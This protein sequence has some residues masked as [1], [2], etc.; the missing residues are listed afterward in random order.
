LTRQA[1]EAVAAATPDP[2]LRETTLRRALKLL[3][4]MDWQRPPPALAQQLH[5]LIR[6]LTRNPDPYAALKQYVDQLAARLDSVWHHRFMESFPPFEAAV[7]MAIVGNQLDAASKAQV[8][9]PALQA[10]FERALTTP[11]VGSITELEE[12]IRNAQSILYL[13][14]NAGEIVFDR[15]LLAELPLGRFSVAVRGAPVLN[16]A[17]LADA[18]AAELGDFCDLMSN[19]SDAPGTLLPDCS[20]EFR[21]RF[22]DADLVLSKGQGNYESLDGIDK[23]IVFLF[24]VKC[25]VVSAALGCPRGSAVI[26]H[27]HPASVNRRS[28]APT[29]TAP[30]V[31]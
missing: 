26:L 25:D 21:Q 20:F 23:H 5:R 17:T 27:Q 22:A 7:R 15:W 4:R 3:A 2:H 12:A 18:E 13:T 28:T 31:P 10:A 19:G 11:L 16:D 30:V 6:D 14:D 29:S 1:G 24:Q 9:E 8:Q